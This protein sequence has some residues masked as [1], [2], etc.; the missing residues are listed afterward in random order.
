VKAIAHR[1]NSEHGI[2]ACVGDG[3]SNGAPGAAEIRRLLEEFDPLLKW[4][5]TSPSNLL[6]IVNLE[7]VPAL[8]KRLHEQIFEGIGHEKRIGA[9]ALDRR[10]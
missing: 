2:V 5:S 6:T 10:A 7:E 8:V 9:T 4:Q 1:A 3:L